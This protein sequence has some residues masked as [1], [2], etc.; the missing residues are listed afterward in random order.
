MDRI[1][2][3]TP[4]SGRESL[5]LLVQSL[6]EQDYP[7]D[8]IVI[9]TKRPPFPVFKQTANYVCYHVPM[10]TPIYNIS[11]AKIPQY[12]RAV[13]LSTTTTKYVAFA[14]DDVMW[15]KDYIKLAIENMIKTESKFHICKRQIWNKLENGQF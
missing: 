15:E 1:T 8:H 3:I 9:W 7:I 14:D 11:P 6:Q 4:S 13:G 2:V 12:L 5:S 10:L